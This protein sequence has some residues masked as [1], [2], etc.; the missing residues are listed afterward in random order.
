MTVVVDK[1][2]QT[3][4]VSGVFVEIGFTVDAKLAAGLTAVDERQQIIVDL[5]TNG[6]SVPGLFAAGDVTTIQ[7][8]QVVISAGEGAKAALA[9][10]AYLQSLG[11]KPKTGKVD[12]GV[13]TPMHH[14][15]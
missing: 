12:W 2:E 1:K 14:E 10:D 8:K 5:A 3:I 4:P 13:S 9:V 7:Q 15:Q 6:T 11:Q